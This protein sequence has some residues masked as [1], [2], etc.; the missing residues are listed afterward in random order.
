MKVVRKLNNEGYFIEDVIIRENSDYPKNYTEIP[1]PSSD[2][3][4]I[5]F[6][7]P[8]WDGTKWVEMMSKEEIKQL[9][10][11]NVEQ[12]ENQM[13]RDYVLDLDVRLI[14]MEFGL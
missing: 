2:K 14:M 10:P 11:V 8:R 13:L 12:S 9:N 1:L 4:Q 3:G 7:K 6:Y 5:G